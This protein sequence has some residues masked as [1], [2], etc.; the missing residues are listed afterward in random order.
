[1]K[2]TFLG[3]GTSTG[4]PIIGCACRVCTSADSRDRRLRCSIWIEVL[5]QSWVV[6]AGPDFRYQ[7]LRAGVK[8]ID[9]LWLTHR[10]RDHVGGLD[11]IRPF[12]YRQQGPIEVYADKDVRAELHR[13]YSYIFD[14]DYPGVPE[15]HLHE[16]KRNQPLILGAGIEVMPI[17]YWHG[18][19]RVMGL[20]IGD[21]AYL[22]DFKSI[23]PDQEALLEGLHTLVVSGLHYEPHHSHSSIEESV[24]FAQRLR[25]RHTWLTHM[26]HKA[27]LHE[28]LARSL[29]SNIQPA[30][31]GWVLE[32]PD[33]PPTTLW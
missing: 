26:S 25:V 16:I 32:L 5:G 31:D 27:G 6:D 3:T 22:T 29:P 10:H 13:V 24:A 1:M 4:L 18:D 28:D 8:R 19:M 15:V 14:S 9:A 12:N 17:E 33:P 7:M 23:D 20:R 21:F 11:D 2:I 30:C